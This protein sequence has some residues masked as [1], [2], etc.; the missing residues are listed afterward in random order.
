MHRDLMLED[1]MKQS[2]HLAII[3][4]GPS[5]IFLLKR[6]LDDVDVIRG[7]IGRISVFEKSPL[8]GVG[9][10]YS[11]LTTDRYNMSNISS[12]ELP[13]L[14]VSFADW[15]RAQDAATLRE[16]DLEGVEISDSEVYSRLALGR[17][18]RS[19]YQAITG[20]LQEAG[21]EFHEY[22]NCGIAD[23]KDDP[24]GD[25]VTLVTMEGNTHTASRLVIAT[26][27]YWAEED[28]PDAG[29]YASPWP[30]SKL[31]PEEGE[32]FNCTIGTLGASLSAFDVVASLAR[33]HGEFSTGPSGRMTYRAFKGA[34]DFR[35]VMH[36]GEGVLPHLQFD[37]DEPFREIYR[38]VSRDELL[39]L[40]DA[41]G[42]L[43][44]ETFF[45]KV[46]RPALAKAFAKDDLPEVVA[47]LVDPAFGL[48]E[49]VEKMS[50]EHEYADAFEGMRHEMVEAEE[51]VEEHK[52]IH[53]KEVI[54]DLMYTLNFHAELMPAED[55]LLLRALVMP[56]LMN[57]IAAM[58]LPSGNSILALHDAGALG[59]ISGKV[60][61]REKRKDEG[62]TIVSVNNEGHE[63]SIRY[64]M[65]IDCSGQ[66]P[67]EPQDYPFQSLV[68]AGKVRKA[69]APFHDARK[70]AD[71][72][73]EE[74]RADVFQ[75]AEGI[76]YP[77]G[78]VDVDGAYRLIGADGKPDARIHDIAF[79]HI[80]GVRPYSYGLQA[81][82][83]TSSIVVRAWLEEIRSGSPVAGD[84]AEI[85]ALYET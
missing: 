59:M 8:L 31:L 75:D 57:V 66:K 39:A 22:A 16:L 67:L 79:P 21:I 15:L 48:R 70:N 62:I 29:Y 64:R 42:F 80:S 4:S 58:P 49:F 52:P 23:V 24:G 81:C 19:Q 14:T 35:L 40:R 83:E 53:W 82:D 25:G 12:E 54:D 41:K 17:Y 5:A 1:P 11:P 77:I 7:K 68:R 6:L 55:H 3:G 51:S 28:V 43:R 26:G 50:D 73:P 56:F 71:A 85:S 27:H 84:A 33:R 61:I 76:V 9:M 45:D 60:E 69:R 72:L 36:S 47:R 2:E 18:L 46:C 32:Y 38:H 74:K 44:L 78:G 37:Q 34:E 63:S 30:I 20:R 13:E 65:F 10:P